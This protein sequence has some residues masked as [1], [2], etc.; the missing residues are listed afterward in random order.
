M[1]RVNDLGRD[2]VPRLLLRLALPAVAA[3]LVNALY[4]IV[5]RMYIGHI[6]GEGKLALTGVGVTFAVIMLVSALASLVCVGGGARAAIHM[7]EGNR[8]RAEEILGSC[9]LRLVVIGVAV[10]VGLWFIRE[11]MLLL[12]GATENTVGYGSDYLGIYLLGS[13]FVM[14]SVGLNYFISTQGFSTVSMATVLIGAVVNIVLDP[15]FIFAFDMGVEGAALATILAQMVSALWVLRFLTGKRTQ[16]RIRRKYLR[17]RWPVLAPVLAIGVSPFVMQATESVLNVAFNSSLKA[18]GGDLAV[19]AMTIASSVMQLLSTIFL[20]FSQGASPIISFNYGAGQS[21]RVKQTVRL[22]VT[23]A[24]TISITFWLL[25]ELFPG[26]FVRIFNDDPELVEYGVWTLRVYGAGMFAIGLQHACQQS[27]V[28]LGQAKIS[29]FL[30]LLRKFILLIPLILILPHFLA[31]QVFAV[32][33]AE[34]VADL[35][36]AA[37]TSTLFFFRLPKILDQRTA[38]LQKNS[39]NLPN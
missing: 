37:T 27:F 21:D 15:I 25:L 11:P 2:P 29:L 38:L 36:A 31:D 34:P 18:Y 33:L 30:A 22:L 32:F 17:L 19:G 23:C 14:A 9:T 26:M 20:G 13:L 24:L 39:E 1:A 5:D 28:A 6:P 10:T 16:L 12:F 7:G 8:D 35:L 3:Q 4:N